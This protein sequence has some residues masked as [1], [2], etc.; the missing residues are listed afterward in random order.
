MR[1]LPVLLWLVALPALAPAQDNLQARYDSAYVAWQDG[2][3][4]HA[5]TVF[6][7][8]LAAPGGERFVE[9]IA[10]L[11]GELHVTVPVAPDGRVPQWSPDGRFA[12]FE[13]GSAT[14]RRTQVLRF[15]DGA[16]RPVALLPGFGLAFPR[17]GSRAA[18]LDP[19]GVVVR[20]LG[21]ERRAVMALP[22]LA[23]RALVHGEGD[24]LYLVAG[25]RTTTDVYVLAPGGTPRALTGGPGVKG[26]PLIGRGAIAY[27]VGNDQVAVHYLA[28]GQ[29]RVF[30]GSAPAVSSDGSTLVYLSSSLD[31]N[32][33]NLLTF[34]DTGPPHVVVRTRDR[35]AAPALSAD[36]RRV[37]YQRMPREDWELYRV[38]ADGGDDVRLTREIQHDVLP[39]FLGP[40]RI[41]AMMGEARHRRSY[42]YDAATGA[43]TRL[44]H[45]NTVRTVAPEYSW[46]PSPDGTRLLIVADRDG[47][48]VSP[49]RG[50]YLMDLTRR[51]TIPELRERIAAALVGERRLREVAERT[52][53]PVQD[54]VTAAVADVSV[55]R[56]HG[57]ARDLF[58]F[59]SKHIAQPGNRP[60]IDYL[61]RTLASFGYEPELQ[62]FEPRPGIRTANVIATLR[63]TTNP[64]AVY[65]VSSHFD[66]VQPGPGADDN[67]SGTT[68]LLEAAR[69]LA[70]RPQPATI[71]FAFFTGEEAGLLG[72][73]EFVRRAQAAGDRI[74]GALN[75]DM[76]GWMNDH[77]LDNTIRYSN[78]WIRDVQHGAA[79]LFTDLITYDSRYYQSTDAAAYY[80]AYGDIVGGIGSYPILGNPHYHQSHDV[81][82]TISQRLVAEVSKTTVATLV[83]LAS[84][85]AL[86]P[87]AR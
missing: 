14:A 85:P 49:E 61:A 35:L 33:V 26:V 30:A 87:S 66:S 17:V 56:I 45:N 40:D 12:A 20:D 34:A 31:T 57:Y 22:G 5:L 82:E 72:S 73:R 71:K 36:G 65:V 43:R 55:T 24:A 79:L 21:S 25:D 86:P 52:F 18:Y 23:P 53:A 28:T 9:P 10:L 51:V 75:N 44:F 77:R 37:V 32:T 69:V 60:A 48:T 81:L 8:L 38:N 19:G 39:R 16:L 42:L 41:L 76:I 54:L 63:G 3:Y 27:S 68:A 80:E 1:S 58:A 64:D 13:V 70:R 6:D 29:T 7:R 46:A 67:T 4:V 74:A 2:A 78:A 15:E 83:V 47:D 62:W 50:V 84:N 59:D 11:T